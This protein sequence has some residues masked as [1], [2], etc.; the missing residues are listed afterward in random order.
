MS[1][2]GGSTACGQRDRRWTRRHPG[3]RGAE[4]PACELGILARPLRHSL[5]APRPESG[6][7]VHVRISPPL[8]AQLFLTLPLTCLTLS[9][10][11]PATAADR[12]CDSSFQ[13]CRTPLITLIRNERV[14]IDVAFWFM[15]DAR[16][17]AELI[18]KH[19]AGIPVR[20]LVDTAANAGSPGNVTVL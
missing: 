1:S 10:A 13:D 20:V 8:V 19:R 5:T 12:L 4:S 15:E 14:G 7:R 2:R 3:C 18:A 9:V 16:Y 11:A 6:M 17:S